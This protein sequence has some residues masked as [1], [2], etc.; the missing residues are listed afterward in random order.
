MFLDLLGGHSAAKETGNEIRHF[1]EM[2]LPGLHC[3]TQLAI[4]CRHILTE[5][6]EIRVVLCKLLDLLE[7]LLPV[8]HEPLPELLSVVA[9]CQLHELL[10]CLVSLPPLLLKQIEL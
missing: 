6:D 4:W 2:P 7:C 3:D 5:V 8:E 1:V 10:V 9:D